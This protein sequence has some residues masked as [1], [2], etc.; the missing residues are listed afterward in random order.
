[1]LLAFLRTSYGALLLN[2]HSRGAAGRNRPLNL[3]T[4]LKE[5][6]PVPSEPEQIRIGNLLEAEH[7]VAQHLTRAIHVVNEYRA[8][9]TAD[10]VTG[11]LDVRA[12][13]R[14]LPAEDKQLDAAVSNMEDVEVEQLVGDAV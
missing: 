5:K 4:L 2:H 3:R 6:I 9:I 1:M 10:V 14:G 11:R 12:A 13:A 7:S 8:R